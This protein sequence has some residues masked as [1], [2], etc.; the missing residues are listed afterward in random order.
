MTG[1]PTR[2]ARPEGAQSIR[3]TRGP[4][5]AASHPR[6]EWASAPVTSQAAHLPGD[7]G[8]PVAVGQLPLTAAA[9]P[10]LGAAGVGVERPQVPEVALVA[11]L[12]GDQRHVA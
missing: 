8:R 12:A 11:E 5:W 9:T 7:V 1:S 4:S 3:A 6:L 2:P 10:H